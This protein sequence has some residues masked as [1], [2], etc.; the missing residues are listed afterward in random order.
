MALLGAISCALLSTATRQSQCIDKFKLF[1]LPAQRR[2]TLAAACGL[3]VALTALP[4][5]AQTCLLHPK[6]LV[7]WWPGDGDANDITGGYHGTLVGGVTFPQG[8]VSQAFSFSGSG[9]V[10]IAPAPTSNDF[11]IDAWVFPKTYPPSWPYVTIYA[12]NRRGLWLKNGRINWWSGSP[13]GDRFIGNTPIGTKAWTHIALTYSNGVFTAYRNGQFDGSSISP[14]EFLPALPGTGIGGH[15]A[16]WE[17]FDG[18]ID[19]VEIF[20]RALDQ[21]EIQAIYAAGTAGKCKP[22]KGMTWRLGAVNT[23]NG[24]VTVGCGSTD[25][26]HP[27]N[28]YIGDELCT[29]ALPLLCFNP[30]KFPVPASVVNSDIYNK[31]SGGIVGT[32]APVAPATTLNSSLAQANAKCV[33][34]FKSTDWRVAEFHDGWGWNFQ[35]YGNVGKPTTRFWVHINDQTKGTCFTKP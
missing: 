22:P 23:T 24:T 34:E 19:E 12:D 35:A 29:N 25:P 9:L 31:W 4:A 8:N 21:S 10:S 3:L 15:G 27:C 6:G 20:S 30:T 18:D 33:D 32:T 5:H 28:P 14:G 7:A 26:V 11:T 1:P 13:P 2:R 16:A 17:P